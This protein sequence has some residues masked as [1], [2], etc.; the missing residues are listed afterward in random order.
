MNKDVRWRQRFQNFKK[1]F[2]QL[3]SA[4]TLT[5][6]RDLSELEQQG[7]IQAFEFT[8]ELAWNTMKD[9]LLSRGTSNLF[10]AAFSA[11][12]I[13]NGDVW[14]EMIQSRNQT[15]HTYEQATAKAIAHAIISKYVMEFEKFQKK[16][17]QLET[18]E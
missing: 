14:M 9:F 10:G 5:E 8:H 2:S 15:T 4:V 17:R 18:E 11:G 13:E 16:F 7:L 12:L 1:A 3:T 6:E